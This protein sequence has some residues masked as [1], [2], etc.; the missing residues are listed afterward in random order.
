MRFRKKP[1]VIEAVRWEGAI[2][3]ALAELF[4]SFDQ[5]YVD[6][7]ALAV[8]TLEGTMFVRPGDWIIRGVQGEYYP[9]KPDIFEATY[10][11]ADDRDDELALLRELE[12]LQWT[13]MGEATARWRAE[14]PQA[15]ASIMPDLG[16]LLKWLMDD[17]DKARGDTYRRAAA[18]AAEHGTAAVRLLCAEADRMEGRR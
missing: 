14:D 17:A 15:R 9:C 12:E 7:R 11:P 2:T 4:G 18:V 5:W 6:G 3:A 8:Q 13:R 1:V 10:E 16:E